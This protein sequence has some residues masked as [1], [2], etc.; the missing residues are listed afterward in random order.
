MR[1]A[2]DR[3][4]HLCRID[5]LSTGDEHVLPAIDY[6]VVAVVVHAGGG[7][8]VEEAIF[9]EYF[10]VSLWSVPVAWQDIWS[11]YQQLAGFA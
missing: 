10:L 7:A 5:V 3:V 9:S 4:L 8:G 1:Y 2:N 11:A 6:I